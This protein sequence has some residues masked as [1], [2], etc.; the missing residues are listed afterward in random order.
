MI[1]VGWARNAYIIATTDERNLRITG[2]YR[3]VRHPLM[4]GTLVF[5]WAQPVMPSELLLLDAGLTVYILLAI[6]LE[7]RELIRK[8]GPAYADYR[9]KV[10]ALIPWR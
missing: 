7:E 4:L 3:W 5:L 8:F 1:P 6:H 9:A 2:P 10:P